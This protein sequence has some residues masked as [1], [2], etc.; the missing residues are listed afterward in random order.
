[1]ADMN[2]SKDIHSFIQHHKKPFVPFHPEK[3]IENKNPLL[4]Q[5]LSVHL[6]SV[7]LNAALEKETPNVAIEK[8][9]PI[10]DLFPNVSMDEDQGENVLDMQPEKTEKIIEEQIKKPIKVGI[11]DFLLYL[12]PYVCIHVIEILML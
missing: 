11:Y 3:V 5:A 6:S 4:I 1:M 9:T 12:P 7:P 10:E 8:D 2:A